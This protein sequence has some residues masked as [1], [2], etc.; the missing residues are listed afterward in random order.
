MWHILF[1]TQ[2]NIWFLILWYIPFVRSLPYWYFWWGFFM[3]FKYLSGCINT[4]RAICIIHHNNYLEL[5]LTSGSLDCLCIPRID[6]VHTSGLLLKFQI[7][8]PQFNLIHTQYQNCRDSV[9]YYPQQQKAPTAE[10]LRHRTHCGIWAHN[11][12]TCVNHCND[13]SRSSL[14]NV[15]CRSKCICSDCYSLYSIRFESVQCSLLSSN[16]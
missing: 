14:F 8:Y 15:H 10:L 1:Y 12:V 3:S 5:S 4:R 11:G 7:C 9:Q 6:I 2:H 16:T 13:L